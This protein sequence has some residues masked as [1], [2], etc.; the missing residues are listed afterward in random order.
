[1]S[2]EET[3]ILARSVEPTQPI[4]INEA[5]PRDGQALVIQTHITIVTKS[6]VTIQPCI[7]PSNNKP[8]IVIS[9]NILPQSET[10]SQDGI[11]NMAQIIRW[12]PPPV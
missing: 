10:P 1:M 11:I 6:I 2:S 8:K 7:I 4:Q 12:E 3:S 9:I 5:I